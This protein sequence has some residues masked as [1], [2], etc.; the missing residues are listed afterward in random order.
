MDQSL[1]YIRLW[2]ILAAAFG[3]SIA[4]VVA[5]RYKLPDLTKRIEVLE[6]RGVKST[7]LSTAIDG[8]R[9]VCRFNQVSCQKEIES[10]WG[11]LQKEVDEKLG[12]IHEKMNAIAVTNAQLIA[13]IDILLTVRNGNGKNN[14]FT[15][16]K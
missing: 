13:K 7:D 12:L 4:V 15:G 14:H 2:P 10:K 11:L 9:T 1:T 8:F 5:V 6:N 3:I 16:G